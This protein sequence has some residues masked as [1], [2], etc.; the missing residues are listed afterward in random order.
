M[1]SKSK[2][3][4]AQVQDE[5]RSIRRD[6]RADPESVPPNAD[7]EV[8]RARARV[9]SS[10]LTEDHVF[11]RQPDS[12]SS[13]ISPPSATSTASFRRQIA[14]VQKELAAARAELAR[15]QEERAD[16]AEQVAS[17]LGRVA[18]EEAVS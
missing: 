10:P 14:A 11:A 15:E 9:S 13:S 16:D 6:P 8:R 2:R 1:A 4:P 12:R 17:L 3:P 7:S 18:G 5:P